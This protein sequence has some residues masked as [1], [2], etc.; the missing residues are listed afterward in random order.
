MTNFLRKLSMPQMRMFFSA[1]EN[2]NLLEGPLFIAAKSFASFGLF[3]L[4][5]LAK[6][7][8]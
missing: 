3:P 4:L 7:S 2:G 5:I 6:K 1:S 8:T